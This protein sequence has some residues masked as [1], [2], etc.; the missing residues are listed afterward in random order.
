MNYTIRHV[1]KFVYE[2]PISESV[3]ETRMQPLSDA[4]QR[5]IRFNLS[6]QPPAR[7]RIYQDPEGNTVHHF[8]IPGHHSR[9]TVTA[10]A[11]VECSPLGE[12][13]DSL[14]PGA[15]DRLDAATADGRFFDML[16]ASAFAKPTDLLAKLALELGLGRTWDP[17]RTLR[18]VMADLHQ[19]FQYTPKSTRVDSPIDEALSTRQGVCQ[20]FAHVMIALVRQI[21]IPCRYVSGY[22]FE[23][24]EERQS[25]DGATHAWVE[26]WLPDLGWVGVDPTHNSLAGEHH[27]RVAVGRDY[28]DVPPTRG[29]FKGSSGVK[30]ELAVGVSIG[31]LEY[32]DPAV[33][34]PWTA[35]E[36]APATVDSDQQQQ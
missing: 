13:P 8:S 1:T 10:E 17:I 12:L 35:R 7:V 32:R 28:A 27:I 26:A 29:V 21:G 36:A 25:L 4:S 14:G 11:F 5:C 31:T 18:M 6:T 24:G 20:D 15:W 22:L 23:P 34:T 3:M 19:R 33:F 30:S 2:V 16:N 9:L